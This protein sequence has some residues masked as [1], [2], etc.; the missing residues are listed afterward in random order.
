MKKNLAVVSGLAVLMLGA[1]VAS[2][3]GSKG[4][5]GVGGEGCLARRGLVD[6]GPDRVALESRL[7]Q[8]GAG[9]SEQEGTERGGEA[10]HG[11]P[12]QGRALEVPARVSA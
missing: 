2:A 10:K 9:A 11:R 7:S 1:G 8:V 4:S 3:G 5:I 6:P 12:R